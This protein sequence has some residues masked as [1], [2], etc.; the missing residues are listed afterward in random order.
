MGWEE[1]TKCVR[2]HDIGW[3]IRLDERRVLPSSCPFNAQYDVTTTAGASRRR[4]CDL[5]FLQSLSFFL[6]K[7]GG[8]VKRQSQNAFCRARCQPPPPLP[9]L[10]DSFLF[11]LKCTKWKWKR[12]LFLKKILL[13][14][15]ERAGKRK[16][17]SFP[18]FWR[19]AF[20]FFFF[21]V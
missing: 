14:E 10:N 5:T 9:S 3:P 19:S 4:I 20:N 12:F 15:E 11:F 7:S 1:G 13:K 6:S 21:P 18:G 2:V 16:G 17:L 8:E